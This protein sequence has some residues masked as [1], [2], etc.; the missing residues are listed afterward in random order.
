M[1]AIALISGGLDSILAARLIKEEGIDILPLNF[2]IPFYHLDKTASSKEQNRISQVAD[3]LG[4][5][6][7]I[8]DISDDFLKL[9]ENPEHGFGANMN[10]CIDCKILMLRKAKELMKEL[11]ALFVVT[12]EVLGQRPMS[13]HKQ[14]LEIIEKKSGLPGLVLR[15]LS[16]KLLPLTMPEE[17]GWVRRN[18]LLDFNGRRRAPQIELAKAFNIKDY[19][20]A[21]GGCLLTEPEFS[22]RLKDLIA[23]RELN[24]NNIELLKVGRH[25]RISQDTKL[26]VG[27]D[28]KEDRRLVNQAKE[29]DYL[30][31]PNDELAGPTCLGRGKGKFSEELIRFSCSITCRYCDLK[32]AISADIVYKI[33]PGRQDKISDVLPINDTE[34]N[35]LRI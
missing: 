22:R 3:N 32:G 30:F 33:I 2:K 10:P 11:D 14:A 28:E 34:L 8:V 29:N 24:M 13:Q 21:A 1:K 7:K 5:D 16:A 12:G 31:M 15:P 19:P 18:K 35:N 20:N 26:I 23:H 9:L 6:L 4:S 17:K 25:F 27:R